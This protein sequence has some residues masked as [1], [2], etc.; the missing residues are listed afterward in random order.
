MSFLLQ[1]ILNFAIPLSLILVGFICGRIAEQRHYA[2]IRRDEA[3]LA[4]VLTFTE[5]AVPNAAAPAGNMVLGAVVIGQDYF[6]AILAGLRQIF[7]GNIRAYETLLD[8]ARREATIR[9]KRAAD[10]QGANMVTNI[11]FSTT[12]IGLAI[13]VVAYGTPCAM[14]E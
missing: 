2:R 1:F 6:K 14:I 10:A 3:E 11:K 8:R 7:G 9:L 5:R 4:H 12:R 13:E